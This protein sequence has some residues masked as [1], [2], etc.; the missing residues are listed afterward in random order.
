VTKPALR[1]V[2]RYMGS[3][4]LLAGRIVRHFP[5]HKSYVEPFGGGASVLLNKPRSVIETYNDLDLE[6]VNFFRVLRQHSAELVRRLE[7]TPYARAEFEESFEPADDPVEQ[8]R[9]FFVRTWMS[10][11]GHAARGPG[12]PSATGRRRAR[13]SLPRPSR[14]RR[15]GSKKPC[16]TSTSSSML[17]GG[18]SEGVD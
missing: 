5:Q 6:V 17:T 18:V 2:L 12:S 11:G 13:R 10:V 9:R 7:L 4:G 14:P 16:L 15:W 8:A 1:P 3:K